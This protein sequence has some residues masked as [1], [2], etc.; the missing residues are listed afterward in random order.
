MTDQT[1]K[2]YLVA[3]LAV[4]FLVLFTFP[5]LG[6]FNRP[7]LVMGLPLL[8]IWVFGVWVCFIIAAGSLHLL[9]RDQATGDAQERSRP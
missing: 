5:V 7:V 4:L 1:R 6:V 8:Y 3:S 2:P 9:F